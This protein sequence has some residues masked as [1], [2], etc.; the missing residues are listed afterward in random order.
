LVLVVQYLKTLATKGKNALIPH[1]LD[2]FTQE[3]AKIMAFQMHLFAEQVIQILFPGQN[4]LLTLWHMNFFVNFDCLFTTDDL[5]SVLWAA[6]LKTIDIGIGMR[7]YCQMSMC[8]RQAYC[9]RLDELMVFGDG[10]DAALLQTRHTWA[11][12]ER[13]YGVSAGYLGQLPE[14]MVEPFAN[15]SVEWQGLMRVPEGGKEVNLD[16]FPVKELWDRL[17]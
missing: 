11:T 7:D 12:E 16:D 17:L 13:C 14:N 8:V 6:S 1:V 9:P 3:Y 5:S 4:S 15:A 2:A 10:E